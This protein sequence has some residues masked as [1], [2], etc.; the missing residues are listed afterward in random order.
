MRKTDE[1]FGF[2]INTISARPNLWHWNRAANIFLYKHLFTY[3]YKASVVSEALHV[4]LNVEV[5]N[6]NDR[7]V[8]R[9]SASS[10]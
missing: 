10:V 2:I 5:S 3:I 8:V 9:V 7:K 6:V 4:L 1:G